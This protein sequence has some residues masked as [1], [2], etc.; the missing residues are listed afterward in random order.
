ME[1]E[2]DSGEMIA[3]HMSIPYKLGTVKKED[4]YDALKQG[5]LSGVASPS[6]EILAYLFVENSPRSILKAV[7]ECGSSIESAQKLYREIARMC[8]IRSLEWEKTTTL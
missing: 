6:K 3:L 8:Q 5:T 1:Q 4:I 2:R 7:Y